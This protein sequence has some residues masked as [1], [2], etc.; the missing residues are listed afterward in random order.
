M[1]ECA[2]CGAC[3]EQR[4]GPGRPRTRCYD[5]SPQAI[6]GRAVGDA[7]GS[8][9]TGGCG[10]PVKGGT[11]S[12]PP[13]QRMC[14]ACRSLPEVPCPVCEKPFRAQ[15][16]SSGRVQ[17]CSK[18]C[19][20][21]FSQ[22]PR[23]KPRPRCEVCDA[24]YRRSYPQ[25]RT[26]SRRCGI[27]SRGQ[28]PAVDRVPP[29]FVPHHCEVCGRASGPGDKWRLRCSTR[30]RID[31]SGLRVKDLYA[32]AMTLGAAG[33]YWRQLLRDYLRERDG[34][35]C[36]ICRGRIDFELLSGPRGDPSGLGASIDHVVPRS[37]EV[38]DDPSNLRLA[39]WKCN[40]ERR[41]GRNDEPVQLALVG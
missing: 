40:H 27:L 12:L 10:R 11:G 2:S 36:G 14:R 7:S 19:G 4:P 39:H 23:G 6:V 15:K 3:F 34:D 8:P 41:D 37:V 16:T 28:V 5:C 18:R 21:L 26:C 38:N 32:T 17:T 25:Q 22:N 1:L 9:C 20:Q 31:A 13:G 30:C 33:G 24:T 35:D 29:P